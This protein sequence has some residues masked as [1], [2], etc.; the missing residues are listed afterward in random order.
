MKPINVIKYMNED[1]TMK[2][3]IE[4]V[5]GY[6]KQV[7]GWTYKGYKIKDEDSEYCVKD[8]NDKT[9]FKSGHKYKVIDFIDKLTSKVNESNH[10]VREPYDRSKGQIQQIID[11]CDSIESKT[12]E[13]IVFD[14]TRGFNHYV[15][16]YKGETYDFNLYRDAIA[17]L[18]M[19]DSSLN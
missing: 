12:G 6:G 17:A 15:L 7:V 5:P 16:I 2:S 9:I 10:M 3:I 14:N 11:L 8:K 13:N 1:D 19:L 18:K 4:Y